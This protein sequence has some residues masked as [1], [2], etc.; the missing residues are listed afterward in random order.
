MTDFATLRTTMVDTQ[1]R[2]SD[3]T[4]FPIIDAMLSVR[5]E[6]YVPDSKQ[7][8]AYADTIVDLGEGRYLLD[9]RTF[10]RIL[11]ALDIQPDEMVLDLGCG[12]GYSAAV[13]GHMAEA[14]V[15]VETNEAMVETAERTLAE[16]GSTNVVVTAGALSEG[17]AKTGPYDVIVI[18]GAVQTVPSSLIDQ[19]ADGGRIACLFDQAGMGAIKVGYKI[20]GAVSWRFVCNAGAPVLEGFAKHDEFSL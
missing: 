13:I 18:E 9:P 12:F 5:R 10:A 4:K 11:D 6:A 2:P 16:E 3:V 17:H 19:L 8:A 20:D 14:V 1:I 15:A 7:A